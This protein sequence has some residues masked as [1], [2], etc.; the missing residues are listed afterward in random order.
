MRYLHTFLTVLLVSCTL[1]M[2]GCMTSSP[3]REDGSTFLMETDRAK[4]YNVRG[5]WNSRPNIDTTTVKRVD[6]HSGD[7]T[8]GTTAANN[9]DK[10][11]FL[12]AGKR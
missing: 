1:W 9:I 5:R 10:E 3:F 6:K 12:K 4:Y 8:Y 2:T 11:K 7:V